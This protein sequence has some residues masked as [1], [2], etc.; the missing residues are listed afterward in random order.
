MCAEV[1]PQEKIPTICAGLLEVH[2]DDKD[3]TGVCSRFLT[4]PA[5]YDCFP[6]KAE[7]SLHERC[8]NINFIHRTAVEFFSR[9]KQGQQF[10]KIE[11]QSCTD[12]RST[13]VRALLAKLNLLGL[14]GNPDNMNASFEKDFCTVVSSSSIESSLEDIMDTVASMFVHEIMRNVYPGEGEFGY[15]MCN[16][17]DRALVTVYQRQQ[18]ISPLSHWSTRWGER[19]WDTDNDPK[20]FDEVIGSSRSSSPYSFHSARSGSR[21][22]LN[23]PVDFLGHAASYDLS[24]YVM[25]RLDLQA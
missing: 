9:C 4:M 23:R 2:L 5:G 20:T 1:S 14:P 18:D 3:S 6:E 13:Y 21:L 11:S 10:L 12:P 8:A 16:D 22:V 7:M 15:A 24:C 17:V 19:L 25:N